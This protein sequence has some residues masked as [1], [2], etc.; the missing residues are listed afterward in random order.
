MK[1]MA[2]TKDY[3]ELAF[4]APNRSGKSEAGA[5]LIAAL[6]MKDYPH[7]WQGKRFPDHEAL[8][9]MAIGKTNLAVRDVAQKKLVGTLFEMGSGMLPMADENDPTSVGI[10]KYSK[11]GGSGVSG[12]IQDLYVRDKFGCVNHIQFMSM[13]IEEDVV[14][15]QELHGVWFDEEC[16]KP[17]LYNE[18]MMRTMTTGG[19]VFNTFTPL[20]GLTHSI[21]RFMPQLVFPADGIVRDDEGVEQGRFV[22]HC[23]WDSAPHLTEEEKEDIRRRYFGDELIARTEGIPTIGEGQVFPFSEEVVK[24][25]P[26]PIPSYWPRAYG[27]DVAWNKTAAVWGAQDPETGVIYIYSEYL[28]RRE[29]PIVHA[30]AIKERGSWMI[31]AVDPAAEK[32]VNPADGMK[33]FDEYKY[34]CNLDIVLADNA[35]EAGIYDVGMAFQTGMLKIMAT[36]TNTLK[37]Y[38]TYRRNADGKVDKKNNPEDDLMDC[39]RYL[40]RTGMYYARPIPDEDDRQHDMFHDRSGRNPVTGY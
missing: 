3:R 37:Q 14:M 32:L 20:D 29:T 8:K 33:I 34:K 40:K 23:G 28:G 7:W 13:D 25:E 36:C 26:F 35:V 9:F 16:L 21:M 17:R 27:F 6:A 30:Q 4:I 22:V 38:R 1:F 18:I 12:A 39:V 11:K 24:C 31:G 15:G 2:A 10:I 5:F 19:F